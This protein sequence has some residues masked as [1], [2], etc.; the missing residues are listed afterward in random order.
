MVSLNNLCVVHQE[1]PALEK[2]FAGLF[3]FSLRS[4][5]HAGGIES[6]GAA[7]VFENYVKN[8]LETKIILDIAG[9]LW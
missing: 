3:C 6:S 7:G 4:C 8:Q 1:S 5:S 9:R 2:S